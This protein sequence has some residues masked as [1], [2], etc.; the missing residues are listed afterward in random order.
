MA[1]LQ[2]GLRQLNQADPSVEVSHLDSGELVLGTCGEVHLERCLRD[3]KDD[4]ARV[5]FKV[6]P[7]LIPFR[8]SVATGSVGAA[9]TRTADR[10]YK[11]RV[12]A[13]PLS[14]GAV[15]WLSARARLCPSV[16][17]DGAEAAARA[18]EAM[19]A[20]GDG[21]ELGEGAA[22]ALERLLRGESPLL[23][24][25]SSES[26]PKGACEDADMAELGAS[27]GCVA[28]GL[29]PAVHPTCVLFAS[30]PIASAL[31]AA[32]AGGVTAADEAG[33]SDVAALLIC[34][35]PAIVAGFQAA[36]GSGPL[37][38]EP[39]AGLAFSIEAIEAVCEGG[40]GGEGDAAL[41]L[42]ADEDSVARC[43][44]LGVQLMAASR[45]ACR[46]AYLASAPRLVEAVYA[47]GL[48][49][50]QE[51]MGRMYGVLSKRRARVTREEM[52]EGTPLF[53]VHAFLPVVESIGFA[54]EIRK[55]TS[56]AA[57]PQLV[58]SHWQRLEVDP[59]EQLLL[60]T[61]DDDEFNRDS[62]KNIARAYVRAVR[63]RKGLLVEDKLVEVA[64]KQRTR[65]RKK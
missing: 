16:E 15:A 62:S 42:V 1:A 50:T 57:H 43:G 19:L 22:G 6:S 41:R 18:A 33:G 65:A 58:F 53:V 54:G 28:V 39:M 36:A 24:L 59:L 64:T 60:S 10:R 51:V 48:Q 12:V 30:K 27:A 63:L 13:R 61:I 7:P 4:F 35:A 29:G 31:A 26:C 34:F 2:A 44:P 21:E 46:Q 55:M 37:C 3:L 49:C 23:S 14:A 20:D 32:R 8:E 25:G 5:E 56:G 40:E 9:E 38:E 17:D 52:I 47:C 11:L 45:D